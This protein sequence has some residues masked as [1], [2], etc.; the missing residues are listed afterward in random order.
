MPAAGM[1]VAFPANRPVW[2]TSVA[3]V[4]TMLMFSASTPP[5]PSAVHSDTSPGSNVADHRIFAAPSPIVPRSTR[6]LHP[7][8]SAAPAT[9]TA[10]T[11]TVLG[12]HI[13]NTIADRRGGGERS[14]AGVPAGGGGPGAR[15]CTRR[16]VVAAGRGRGG[17]GLPHERRRS[18]RAASRG[19]GDPGRRAAG[20][21]GLRS[22][23][24]VRRGG[25]GTDRDVRRCGTRLR[26]AGARGRG[27][28][29][30]GAEPAGPAG[31]PARGDGGAAGPAAGRFRA[32]PLVFGGVAG[33]VRRRRGR[34][35]RRHG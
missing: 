28:H 3:A 14:R 29:R 5:C 23:A 31:A 16:G 21:A 35:R 22:R 15:A 20:A 11:G 6:W 34:L 4:G 13:P 17:R 7:P 8:P 10:R 9:T 32:R 19:G 26:R 1:T 30:A 2:A 24:P 25:R 12:A 27:L 18:R 33:A